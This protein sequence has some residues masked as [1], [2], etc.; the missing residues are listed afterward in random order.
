[1][2]NLTRK[3]ATKITVFQKWNR[4]PT[5]AEEALSGFKKKIKTEI[6]IVMRVHMLRKTLPFM[7]LIY[8]QNKTL[9]TT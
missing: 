2:S 6:K 5:T 3:V 7:E 1:M 9:W 4:M 8:R